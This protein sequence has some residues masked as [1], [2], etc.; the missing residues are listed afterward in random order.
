MGQVDFTFKNFI[1]MDFDRSSEY[2]II[3]AYTGQ[4][5]HLGYIVY[6]R[7]RQLR[8]RRYMESMAAQTNGI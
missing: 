3:V 6:E 7:I 4:G 2:F 5:L 1:I 8:A